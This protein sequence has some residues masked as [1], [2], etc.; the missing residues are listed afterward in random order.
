[1]K[2][3]ISAHIT[4]LTSRAFLRFS[5]PSAWRIIIN[6]KHYNMVNT[7]TSASRAQEEERD[8]PS[9]II[10]IW[11]R[12]GFS[13]LHSRRSDNEAAHTVE[14]TDRRSTE[15]K[16]KIKVIWRL[17]NW[18]DLRRW[19]HSWLRIWRTH[20]P[21]L[22]VAGLPSHYLA[23][24]IV[25]IYC[26]INGTHLKQ[27]CIHQAWERRRGTRYYVDFHI[28]KLLNFFLN[29]FPFFS[30]LRLPKRRVRYSVL[31]MKHYFNVLSW[32]F[33]CVKVKWCKIS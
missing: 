26:T 15:Q 29:V 13:L 8:N 4:S 2:L 1:M 16:E 3:E 24:I 30:V 19:H 32:K 12:G 10:W 9:K 33:P 11:S 21:T 28:Q 7:V 22:R 5:T 31:L 17:I 14:A 27:I 6:K 25:I 23:M 18:I 20:H